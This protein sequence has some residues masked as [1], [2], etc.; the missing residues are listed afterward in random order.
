MRAGDR[1]VCS[2]GYWPLRHRSRTSW[3]WP[4][5]GGA[6]ERRACRWE[7]RNSKAGGQ[8]GG[9]RA[10]TPQWKGVRGALGLPL[11]PG[12]QGPACPSAVAVP[13]SPQA[14]CWGTDPQH[15]A[16]D[17][18]WEQGGYRSVKEDGLAL[19]AEGWGGPNGV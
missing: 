10:S 8:P 17:F 5:G 12:G 18:I 19:A 15:P 13:R 16:W 11:Q 1:K 14:G 3:P 2:D 4:G 7:T 6:A 9:A